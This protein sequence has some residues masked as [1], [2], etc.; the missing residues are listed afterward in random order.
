M[1]PLRGGTLA[2]NM[3]EQ[4]QDIFNQAKTKRTTV[5]WALQWLWNQPEIS[6]VLS[7]M[8]SMEQVKEN[9]ESADKAA[10]NSLSNEELQLIR[11]VTNCH[12]LQLISH[13]SSLFKSIKRPSCFDF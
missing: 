5:D 9:I 12:R 2:G 11:K 13:F 4:I 3:P 10:I 7:G 1:E 6:V 8:S